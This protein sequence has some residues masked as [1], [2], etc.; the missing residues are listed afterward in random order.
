MPN[1]INRTVLFSILMILVAG[2][3][4]TREMNDE[5]PSFSYEG[6][7]VGMPVVPADGWN[8]FNRRAAYP[9]AIPHVQGEVVLT[10]E[11]DSTGTATQIDPLFVSDEQLEEPAL[12]A[13]RTTEFL[14]IEADADMNGMQF[15]LSI[16]YLRGSRHGVSAEFF[17]V[18][19]EMPFM[20]LEE[21]SSVTGKRY[22]YGYAPDHDEE[23]VE[24]LPQV[25]G[26]LEA[27]QRLVRFPRNQLIGGIRNISV[28]VRFTVNTDGRAEDIQITRSAGEDFDREAR[29]AVR[30]A[31]FH[32]G[33]WNG[34]PVPMQITIPIR[35][36]TR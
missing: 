12:A 30:Q 35:W 13:V 15:T 14:P 24:T 29:A 17:D 32:P 7:F 11:L 10:I 18:R 19:E 26:G 27:L 4:S 36:R 21:D 16:T 20:N 28:Y 6:V 23:I 9:E 3:A 8:S 22:L 2:C 5:G 33:T 31:R 25:I 1:L 34:E